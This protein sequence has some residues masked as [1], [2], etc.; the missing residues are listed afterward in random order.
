MDFGQIEIMAKLRVAMIAPPWLSIPPNGYGGIEVVVDG[1]TR[2]LT[3]LGVCVEL[4]SIGRSRI[5]GVK[6]HSLYKDEQYHHIHKTIYESSP[7]VLAHLLF[8]LDK[9]AADG[10]FDIIHDHNGFLGPAMLRWATEMPHLP[11]VLHTLHG[12]PF[13]SPKPPGNHNAP[14]NRP[15]WQQLANAKNLYI[16]GIS[17]TLMQGAPPDLKKRSLASVHN[18]IEVKQFQFRA[19]KQNHFITLARFS[20]EKGQHIAAKLCDELGYGLKMAGT[21]AGINSEKQLV[22]ELANPLSQYRSYPDF[23]YYSDS[24]W[25]LTVKNS[26]I[27][28]VGNV[29]GQRKINFI[30]AAKALLFPIDWEEPFGM[31]VI[32]A[33]ACGTPVIAMNR[34]AMPE[35]IEHGVNGFLAKSVP[36]FRKYMQRIGEI[37]PARC[38]QTVEE[39]FSTPIMAREYLNRYHQILRT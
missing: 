6:S 22:L 18:G 39:L 30:G 20:R 23:R 37:D 11:P 34:G 14:D 33:L 28:Y 36:E 4:F 5:K 27:T 13:S 16:V 2:E 32:E 17:K 25:P 38:R 8:A 10:K 35:I 26:R 31:A 15:M 24:I 19:K 1:L 29:G 21:V 3:K 9:I 12:P 7:I